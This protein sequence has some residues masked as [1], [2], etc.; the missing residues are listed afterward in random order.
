MKKLLGN[1]SYVCLAAAFAWS[2]PVIAQEKVLN[3]MNSGGEYGGEGCDEDER[4]HDVDLQ[5]HW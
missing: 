5:G 2:T 1:I 3:I 4:T